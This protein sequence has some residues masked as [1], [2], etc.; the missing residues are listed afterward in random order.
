MTTM[1]D[2]S[3]S[4]AIGVG[5]SLTPEKLSIIK[6][7]G[8]AASIWQRQV[9]PAFQKWIDDL[10]FGNL[11]SA[12]LILKPESVQTDLE[13]LCN[14]SGMPDAPQ[15]RHLIQDIATLTDIFCEVMG[16]P[17]VRLRLDRVTTNACRKFHVDAVVA[18]LVCTYRGTGTQYGISNN[19]AE[20]IRVFTV[21]TGAPIVLRGNL[22]PEKP[23]SGLLHRSPP[24]EGSGE[25]RLVLVLDPIFDTEQEV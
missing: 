15:R 1:Q 22:W 12:R 6:D 19:G 2:A 13:N 5:I 8:C 10:D 20:P 25:T 21:P 23:L 16:A 4:D 14:A 11:P 18:R 7:S 24:I 3:K 17:L 9:T